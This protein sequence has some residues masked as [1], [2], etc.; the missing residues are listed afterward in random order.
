MMKSSHFDFPYGY[1]ILW[2]KFT[3]PLYIMEKLTLANKS[4]KVGLDLSPLQMRIPGNRYT[5]QNESQARIVVL[6]EGMKYFLVELAK[7]ICVL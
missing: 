5:S 6:Y 4:E 2:P 7:Q 1:N 3:F